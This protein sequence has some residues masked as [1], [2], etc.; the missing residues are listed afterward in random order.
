M[1]VSMRSSDFYFIA[2]SCSANAMYGFSP[3]TLVAELRALR[4]IKTGEEIT[5]RY[6][7]QNRGTTSERQ[8]WLKSEQYF[9]CKCEVCTLPAKEQ[10]ESDERR[11][12]IGTLSLSMSLRMLLSAMDRSI[13]FGKKTTSALDKVRSMTTAKEDGNAEVMFELDDQFNELVPI[14]RPE[15]VATVRKSVERFITMHT[16][17][18]NAVEAEKLMAERFVYIRWISRAYAILGDREKMQQ[19]LKEGRKAMRI[20]LNPNKGN[21]RDTDK[22]AV[23]TW[24]QVIEDVTQHPEWNYIEKRVEMYKLS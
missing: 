6:G 22:D 16:D 4:P 1:F 18:L 7:L 21:F 10:K 11:K 23:A 13:V 8:A 2:I 19:W 9:E 17:I 3:N 14:W 5:L 20:T 15:D 24:D 12:R